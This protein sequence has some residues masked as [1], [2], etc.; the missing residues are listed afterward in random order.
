MPNSQNYRGLWRLRQLPARYTLITNS[1]E[2]DNVLE[3]IDFPVSYRQNITGVV[4][5]Y[6]PD[7]DYNAIFL[8]TDRHPQD[9][10]SVYASLPEYSSAVPIRIAFRYIYSRDNGFYQSQPS[11]D[12][13]GVHYEN[14]F[15]L[16]G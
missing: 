4:T 1:Q 9:L 7:G 8:T 16:G 15:T 13:R 5:S 10:V 11:T 14:P 3:N 12:S 6:D 2:I